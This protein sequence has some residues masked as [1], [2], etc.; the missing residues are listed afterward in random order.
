MLIS[1][2]IWPAFFWRVYCDCC[3]WWWKING[4]APLK[5]LTHPTIYRR[6]KKKITKRYCVSSLTTPTQLR[7]CFPAFFRGWC[8]ENIFRV[9]FVRIFL[10]RPKIYCRCQWTF[11]FMI[12]EESS[13]TLLQNMEK[14]LD[15]YFYTFAWVIKICYHQCLISIIMWAT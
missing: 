2:K 9:D 1:G 10:K 12:G 11:T 14:T 8:K 13:S 15:Q 6:P 7:K 5:P 3:C 4:A